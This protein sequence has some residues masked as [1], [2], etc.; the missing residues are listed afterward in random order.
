MKVA[1]IGA[2]ISGLTAAYLLAPH[3]RV[4]LFEKDGRLG[5]HAHTAHIPFNDS[6]VSVDT[7]FMV[8]NPAKYPYFCKL[9]QD[10]D[11]QTIDT[12]MSFSVSIPGHV[13]FSSSLTGILG[14]LRQLIKPKYI[15]FIYEILAFNSAAKASL[16]RTDSSETLKDFLATNSF[17]KELAEWY[18]FPMV[19]SIWSS[20][21]SQVGEFPAR[22]TFQFL[23]NH[24]LLSVLGGPQWKTIQAGSAH[25]V[26]ALSARLIL[27]GVHIVTGAQIQGIERSERVVRVLSDQS[28]TFDA[29]IIATHADE[30]RTILNNKSTDEDKILGLFSYAR[31]TAILHNDAGFMP[32]RR[33]AWAAWNYHSDT[34]S[35]ASSDVSLTYNMN[36]LQSIPEEFPVF[37]SLNPHRHIALEHIFETHTYSHPV[38]NAA[39]RQ[40]QKRL[41]EIQGARGT[42]F[43][44]A[45]WG[46]GFHEDG[47][48]SAMN[49]VTSLNTPLR[50]V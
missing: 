35:E 7:G 18:L 1:V 30:A 20:G 38:L 49:A 42:F 29:V 22:E 2:G 8:F 12:N 25:Y 23:D 46:N 16:R 43:A 44:G 14:N 26:D 15:S 27:E 33:S 31:N 11:V 45:H 39:A 19:A 34:T 17:S 47:V 6:V 48:V 40:A 4:T 21:S 50:F 10:L 3:A 28:E 24:Q 37:V 41:P 5:G 9:I 36:Y 32:K 13:E